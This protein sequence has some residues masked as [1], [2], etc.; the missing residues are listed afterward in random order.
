MTLIFLC[1]T[2]SSIG[3]DAWMP[4]PLVV[5]YTRGLL[6]PAVVVGVVLIWGND[7]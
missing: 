2:E 1:G 7:Q 5:R 4:D 3:V 6:I